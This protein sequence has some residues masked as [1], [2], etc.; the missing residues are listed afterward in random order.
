MQRSRYGSPCIFRALSIQRSHNRKS[1]KLARWHFAIDRIASRNSNCSHKLCKISFEWSLAF[2]AGFVL[3]IFKIIEYFSDNPCTFP[4]T[5]FLRR[6]DDD[7]RRKN[8]LKQKSLRQFQP[9]GEGL[10]FQIL[11]LK[12]FFFFVS[13]LGQFEPWAMLDRGSM[14]VSRVQGTKVVGWSYSFARERCNDPFF[15]TLPP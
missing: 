15:C 1:V 14:R 11:P 6:K 13:T 10:T 3:W 2:V 12:W 9:T 5:Q 7:R 4:R 8:I